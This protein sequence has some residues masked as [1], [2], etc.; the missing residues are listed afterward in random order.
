MK[1]IWNLRYFMKNQLSIFHIHP[2]IMLLLGK[3]D[4]SLSITHKILCND[5]FLSKCIL[6][7]VRMITGYCL[8]SFLCSIPNYIH[9]QEISNSIT[10]EFHSMMIFQTRVI[11][12][13][14]EKLQTMSRM[15]FRFWLQPVVMMCLSFKYQN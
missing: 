13:F 4:F 2:H 1:Y 5:I 15:L 7:L 8:P 12:N 6:N 11:L 9:I 14:I 3:K 10:L